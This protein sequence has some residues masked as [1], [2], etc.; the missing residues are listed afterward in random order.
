M[1]GTAGPHTRLWQEQEGGQAGSLAAPS[2]KQEA[3]WAHLPWSPLGLRMAQVGVR[4]AGET[5]HLAWALR[6]L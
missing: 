2:C 6:Y 3:A 1:D 5:I 4:P